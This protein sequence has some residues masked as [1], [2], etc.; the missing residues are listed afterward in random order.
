MNE[1][2]AAV[3]RFLIGYGWAGVVLVLYLSLFKEHFSAILRII[4]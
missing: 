2:L 1:R 4:S 3:G